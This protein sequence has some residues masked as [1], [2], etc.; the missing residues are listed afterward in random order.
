MATHTHAHPIPQLVLTMC[1]RDGEE[2][3]EP[4][5]AQRDRAILV[6]AVDYRVL[7]AGSGDS[8]PPILVVV[9][10]ATG[11]IFAH[12]VS[13][14]S[15]DLE[16]IELVM[17]GLEAAGHRELVFKMDQE[18]ATTRTQAEVATMRPTVGEAPANGAAERAVQ[19]VSGMTR[20][21]KGASERRI[22]AVAPPTAA[23]LQW[24]VLH[25]ANT[26]SWDV[27]GVDGKT[28]L[29]RARGT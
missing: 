7:G 6:A 17:H 11:M 5:R 20:V 27:V 25:G 15:G 29:Q 3:A 10:S 14:V 18:L 22:S 19:K 16:V 8:E 28:A 2:H 24:L 9:G 26:L 21:T 1:A 23:A 12:P 4:Q 13:R